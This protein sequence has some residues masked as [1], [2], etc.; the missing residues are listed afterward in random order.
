MPNQRHEDDES[1]AGWGGKTVA[2]SS[3][4]LMLAAS[5]A[6][7]AYAGWWLDQRYGTDPWLAVTGLFLG[8]IAGFIQLW[9]VVQEAS[10]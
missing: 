7:G 1:P 9:K 5:V 6:I 8:A 2:L 3:A 10:D 4:G